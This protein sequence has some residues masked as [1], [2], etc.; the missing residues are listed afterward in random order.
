MPPTTN[1]F[2]FEEMHFCTPF[3]ILL[4]HVVCK[5]GLLV[6]PAKISTILD[7]VAPTSVREMCAMLGHTGYYDGSSII[8]PR[9]WLHWKICCVKILSMSGHQNANKPW[10]PSKKNWLLPILVFPDWSKLFHVHVDASS[11]ALGVILAQPGEGNIDHPIY[12][13]SRK[14]SDAKNNYMTTECEGLAM[15]YALQKFFHYLLGSTFK[16]FTDHSCSSI[17][18]TSGVGWKNCR[19]LFLFQEFDFEVV[20]KPGKHNVGPD[21]LSWIETGEACYEPR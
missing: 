9:L 3:G 19:W 16:F 11:I 2:E 20:V 17:W 4:G 21:H 5:D 18:S 6:D 12:F 7:M 10:I 15:V 8:M 14:L 1:I 13:S